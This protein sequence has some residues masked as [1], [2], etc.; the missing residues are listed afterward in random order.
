MEDNRIKV[1]VQRFKDRPTL[2]LQWLDPDT[3][4]RKSKSAEMQDEGTAE[5][6]RADLE[7]QLNHG[8]YQQA[9]KLNWANFRQLLQDEYLPGARERTREKYNTVLD[10]FEQIVNPTKLRGINE[11][12]ISLFVKGSVDQ[13]G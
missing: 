10:V 3:G 13:G 9:S 2:M 5:T 6:K 11:R 8:Q 1:W 12:T 4:R 7:Y